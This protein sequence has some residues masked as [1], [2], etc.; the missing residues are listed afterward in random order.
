MLDPH[1]KV[2]SSP[3]LHVRDDWLALT[4]E[5]VLEPELPI[6]D[7]HHHIWDR[8]TGRYLFDELHADISAGHNV[9]STVF[10][11]CR[12][13]YSADREVAMKPVGEVEFINGLAARF[14]SGAYGT[15]RGCAAIVGFADLMLGSAVAPV[16]EALIAA[17]NGRLRGIRNT[18]AWHTNP[19]I[20]TNPVPPPSGMLLNENF[21]EAARLLPS[22]G[23]TLDVWAYHTQLD[24]VLALAKACPHT[25]IILNHVGGSL[26]AGPYKG[27]RREVLAE[28]MASMLNLAARPNVFVKIGGMGMSVGG[29]DFHLS[30]APPTSELLAI[31]WR[32]YISAVIDMFEPQRCMFE[33]N[34]PVDKGMFSYVSLWNAFKTLTRGMSGYERTCMFSATARK[35]YRIG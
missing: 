4:Q 31:A 17:G 12:S 23:L 6:I 8:N 20:R 7:A 16:L 30:S 35:V 22:Y 32:P 11:Q 19:N 5:Q 25:T 29:W 1:F 34:F 26:G 33:S 21:Q 24:E 15:A 2:Q 3:H 10:V 14:A 18:T 9:I 13:M 27:R 28:W